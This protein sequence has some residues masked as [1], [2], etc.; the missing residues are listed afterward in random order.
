MVL[1]RLTANGVNVPESDGIG[2]RSSE[3]RRFMPPRSPLLLSRRHV[4]QA[5]LA[6]TALPL[7]PGFTGH[8]PNDIVEV[9]GWILKRSDLA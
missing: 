5:L 6:T 1:A 8:S 4:L 3:R 9:G 2:S 7:L